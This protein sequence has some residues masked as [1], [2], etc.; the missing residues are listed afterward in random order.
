MS[1][2]FEPKIVFS[3]KA[4]EPAK[5]AASELSTGLG[6]ML[7]RGVPASGNSLVA[8]LEMRI[9][10]D[11]EGIATAVRGGDL[12]GDAFSVSR[13]DRAIAIKSGSER[14]LIHAA[15]AILE[16]LGARFAPG[17][18]PLY[19]QTGPER[20]Y[21]LGQF[22]VRPAFT[23][24]AMISDLMTWNYNFADRLEIHLRHD[25][26]FIPWMARRGLNAFE[27]IRHAH[28]TRLKIGEL[29]PLM[30]EWGVAAEYGGHVLQILLPREQF[31]AHPEYFPASADGQRAPRGNL[32]VSNP[33]A[34]A[35]VR[36]D[37]LRY[38]REHPENELLHV[39]GADVWS[40][41]WCK[42]G[43][44]RE[45]EPQ[46]Q[47]MEVVNAIA[48]ELAAD[49]KA[50]PI[51]YLAYHDTLEPHRGLK[52]LPNVWVE[53][54]PRERCYTHAIDDAECPINRGQFGTLKHHLEIFGGRC[55]VFEYYADAI[56]FGGLSFATPTVIARDMRAYRALGIESVSCLTFGA[57]SALAYPVNLEAFARATRSTDFAADA[58]IEGT[59]AGRH[60][61][62]AA[63]MSNAYRVLERASKLVLDYADVMQPIVPAHRASRKAG[64][65]RDAVAVFNE[66]IAAADA[67]DASPKTRLGGAEREIWRYSANVLAAISEYLVA[68]ADSAADRRERAEAAIAKI[69]ESITI[70]RAIDLDAKGTWAAFD[71]EWIRELWLEGMRRGLDSTAH[72]A[73]EIF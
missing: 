9:V 53:W 71:L 5:I 18:A 66:A 59:A 48:E 30:R 32:C 41:A 52:P 19:P 70:I 51:A 42:C 54:A 23:R 39:W 24:R 25:R 8:P 11:G 10:L 15:A 34:M 72:A 6:A 14:G 73:T 37:A 28:D 63:Q 58:S 12:A 69:K 36:K 3:D 26:E 31:E 57:F 16:K 45:L 27:F 22:E 40:G 13:I 21:G 56:L 64:E 29:S 17:V 62:C 1:G 7:S 67:I 44:C 60:P 38:V 4:G 49:S 47:Y 33:D 43:N 46:L 2:R 20:L 65:L 50:P 55:N 35:M 61:A 68:R